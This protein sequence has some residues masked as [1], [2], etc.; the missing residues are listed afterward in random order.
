MHRYMYWVD[1]GKPA[2]LERSR[3]DG[4]ERSTFVQD[5]MVH[6]ADVTIDYTTSRW[7]LQIDLQ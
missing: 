3:L 1:A 7:V 4:S 6:P 2:R 5:N